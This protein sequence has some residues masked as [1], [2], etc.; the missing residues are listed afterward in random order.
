[1]RTVLVN[2]I[3]IIHNISLTLSIIL[4]KYFNKIVIIQDICL[5]FNLNQIMNLIKPHLNLQN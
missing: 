4:D 1:M 2:L 5:Q 3:R